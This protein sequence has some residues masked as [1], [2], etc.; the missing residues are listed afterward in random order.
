MFQHTSENDNAV[1][2]GSKLGFMP[3][4]DT[5]FTPYRTVNAMKELYQHEKLLNVTQSHMSNAKY[6]A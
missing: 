1:R 4:R 5:A 6:N 2:L 3:Q